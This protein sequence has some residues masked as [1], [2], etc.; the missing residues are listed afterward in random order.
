MEHVNKVRTNLQYILS[1]IIA[2]G[3]QTNPDFL[4]GKPQTVLKGGSNRQYKLFLLFYNGTHHFNGN[5][6]ILI[7]DCVFII[8]MTD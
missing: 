8:I 1:R 5:V 2:P 4:P 7:G 6:V 3:S